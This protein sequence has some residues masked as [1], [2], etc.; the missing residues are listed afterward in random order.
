MSVEPIPTAITDPDEANSYLKQVAMKHA[1]S[2]RGLLEQISTD[3]AFIR[4]TTDNAHDRIHRDMPTYGQMKKVLEH[5]L[6]IRQM[7]Y[8]ILAGVCYLVLK[9]MF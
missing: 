7:C 1:R 4:L 8:Y 2:D 9:T 5:L 6:S 3:A